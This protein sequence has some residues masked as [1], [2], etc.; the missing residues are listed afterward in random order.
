MKAFKFEND[1]SYTEKAA[2]IFYHIALVVFI[3]GMSLNQPE[4]FKNSRWNL[5]I[6][7]FTSVIL[8]YTFFLLYLLNRI[9][10]RLAS[11]VYIYTTLSNLSMSAWLYYYYDLDFM[12]NFLFNTF[13][14]CINIV[15]A[16]FCIGRR[17]IY[18]SSVLY[19]ITF[20]PLV[21]I[22]GE[23]FLIRNSFTFVFLIFA[24]ALAVSGFISILK[25]S[26]IEELALKEEIINKDKAIAE[27]H[28]KR[29]NSEI[30]SKRIEI[31]AKKMV[32]L[33]HVEN[34]NNFIKKLGTLKKGMKRNEIKLLNNIIQQHT[35]DHHEKYWKEFESS[36]I[37]INPHFYK[38]LYNLCP[39]L[40]P[41]ETRLA[42]LIH[43]GLSSKQIGN[44]TSNTPQSI[45]VARSRIRSKLKLSADV[46]LKTFLIHI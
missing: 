2:R 24:L 1:R 10:F 33:E 22:S 13:M 15:G 46:N 12:G 11:F 36:F 8:I 7:D 38:K 20:S 41:S 30:E 29:L 35:I 28:Q 32:M 21:F 34:N 19:T 43:M 9:N 4:Y 17:H 42:A 27:E 3:V 39:D 16:G 44:I 26:Y 18:I 45:D 5:I 37:E 40:T 25:Q 23:T 31:A 6:A 14:Y